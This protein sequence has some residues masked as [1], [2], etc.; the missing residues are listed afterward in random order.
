M[1][2]EIRLA[3][4]ADIGRVSPTLMRSIAAEDVRFEAVC[5]S[6]AAQADKAARIYG[7]RWPFEDLETMLREAEPDAVIIATADAQRAQWAKTCLKHRSAVLI[8]NA[9]ARGPAECKSLILAARKANR[10]VMIGLP[11][12]FSPAGIRLR[13]LRES[14][15][16]GPVA[17]VDLIMTWPRTPSED[18]TTDLALPF[19][20]VFDAADRL[21]CCGIEAQR[22]WAAEQ[23]YGHIAAM[24]LAKDG[25]L[26]TLGLHHAGPPQT[27]GTHLELRSED[28]GLLIVEDD[29]DLTCTVGTQLVAKHHPRLGVGDDPCIEC[30]YAGMIT[31]FVTALRDRQGVPFGLPSATGSVALAGAIFKAAASGRAVTVKTAR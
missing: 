12:R 19:D 17:A 26:A 8:L 11:Q 3:L 29:V 18:S 2:R 25:V 13:R 30:G 28:G 6:N 21:R 20:L 14:G 22:L 24:V 4:A 1:T 31:A 10:Q 23:P 16:L 15:R 27:A 9:P 5:A 7:A